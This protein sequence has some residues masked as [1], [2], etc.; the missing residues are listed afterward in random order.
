MDRGAYI[1][2]AKVVK[3]QPVPFSHKHH[4]TDDGID[5]RYCHAS[6]ENSPYAGVPTT[7]TCMSCHSKLWLNSSM[8]EPV[9][10]SFNSDVSLQWTRVNTVPDFVYFDHSIH[11][12]R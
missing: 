8:L 2:D 6:V 4:V 3:P 7:H 10:S 9:R 12:K 1:T 5:C 11:V